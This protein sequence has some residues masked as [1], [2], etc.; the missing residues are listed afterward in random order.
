M[1]T[2]VGVHTWRA[3]SDHQEPLQTATSV[4]HD[5]VDPLIPPRARMFTAEIDL[6][7]RLPRISHAQFN[8]AITFILSI[9]DAPALQTQDDHEILSMVREY[10]SGRQMYVVWKAL[11]K[12]TRMAYTCPSDRYAVNPDIQ[13]STA[14]LASSLY[15]EIMHRVE[16]ERE[17]HG[18]GITN[19]EDMLGY[20]E[21]D[22]CRDE[23][24]AYKAQIRFLLAL[25]EKDLHPTQFSAEERGD[26]GLA[27]RVRAAWKALLEGRFC[28]WYKWYEN[29]VRTH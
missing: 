14:F 19:H 16:C 29:H 18:L 21:P 23:E 13:T 9:A 8:E 11:T 3:Q 24:P 2:V 10:A 22:D 20:I 5:V 6:V 1:A 15:H 28:S 17:M 26:I 4:A 25:Y 7:E 12:D 27:Q